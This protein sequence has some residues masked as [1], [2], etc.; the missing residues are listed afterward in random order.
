MS[1]APLKTIMVG[2]ADNQRKIAYQQTEPQNSATRPSLF[3]LN[4]FRSNMTSNKATE[5]NTWATQN[6]L[7]MTSFD[8][9]GHGQSSGNFKD[10]TIS[11]WLEES[12]QLFNSQ[13]TGPQ[14][15]VG[16]SMGGWMSL[17]LLKQHLKSLKAGEESRI[18]GIALIAPAFNMTRDL[19]WMKMDDDIR[20]IIQ[21]DGF[22]MKPRQ[23]EE[24]SFPITKEL[25]RDGE[26]HLIQEVFAPHCP[27]R[28]IQ[29]MEDQVVPWRHTMK[30]MRHLDEPNMSF[31]LI[32]DAGHRLSRPE[33]IKR[34]IQLIEEMI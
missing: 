7:A 33:D 18:K 25:I 17:L 30:L 3:W 27:I 23:N 15:L 22:W 12:V 20:S 31:N 8:Y 16:S 24:D 10:G 26:Y 21:N 28:I 11:Q 29:G 32:K 2:P 4:G 5:V 6:N 9:S 1:N 13:T 34:L 19:I 14:I